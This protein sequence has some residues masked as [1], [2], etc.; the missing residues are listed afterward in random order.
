MKCMIVSL[1]FAAVHCWQKLPSRHFIIDN[2]YV[3]AIN[4]RPNQSRGRND[5]SKYLFHGE[6]RKDI[7]RQRVARIVRDE[8]SDIIS[9]GDFEAGSSSFLVDDSLLLSVSISSVELNSDLSIAKVYLTIGGNSIERRKVFVWLCK[10]LGQLRHSLHTRLRNFKRV[11]TISLH[12]TDSVE[13]EFLD[14]AFKE[15]S[16]ESKPVID[17]DF[18]SLSD[19]RFEE[20]SAG[21]DS[22]GEDDF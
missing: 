4:M 15:I 6:Q 1:I 13:E 14:Q 18:L 20:I 7:R 16:Q 12:L 8:L 3:F 22:N 21:N 11:P 2:K 17:D 19:I 10:H 9:F 5:N